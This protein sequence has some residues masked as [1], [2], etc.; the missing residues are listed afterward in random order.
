MLPQT[1]NPSRLGA[2]P[3]RGSV[4]AWGDLSAMDRPLERTWVT[5]S[6]VVAAC[7]LL[8]ATGALASAYVR[9]GLVRSVHIRADRVVVATVGT[10]LF[11]EFIPVD[12]TVEPRQTVYLDA[13]DGGQVAQVLVEEGALVKAGEP[14]VRLSNTTLQLEV[15]NS[16]AQLSEQL[17]RLT[18][19]KL[20][21][22]QSRLAHARDLI[23]ARFQ[24]EQAAHN[25]ERL[26][27]LAGSGVVRRADLED[28]QLELDRQKELLVALTHAQEVDESLQSKQ[29]EQLDRTV[30]GLEQNLALARQN[31]D[32][33]TIRAPFAGQLTTLEAHLGESK[34]PGQR[35]GQV[36]RLDGYKVVA[37]IDEH[38]LP[39]VS[40]GQHATPDPDATLPAAQHLTVIKVYPEVNDRQFKVDLAFDGGAPPSVRRGQSVPL[41]LQIGGERRGLILANGPFYDDSGGEWAFV[42]DHDG[43]VAR[44]R[45]IRLGRRNF[46]QV[47]V[48]EGLRA[49]DRVIISS[50]DGWKDADRIELR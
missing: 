10:G 27:K 5:R 23:D 37:L 39:R 9:Y 43:D 28:A 19:T 18:S 31:L 7:A 3:P 30:T 49:G 29:I 4:R 44:R 12:G 50:Y 14:L 11:R 45:I 40:I 32:N 17:D 25:L 34:R 21:F 20:Q 8:F 42:L 38:Y 46:E 16:D 24:T 13:V 22:E 47:E 41:R 36:D 26:S 33:L 15:L 48:L 6:R 1:S 35:I 2:L